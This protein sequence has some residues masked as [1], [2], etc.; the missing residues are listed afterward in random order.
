MAKLITAGCGISQLGF[1]KWPTWPKY[2]VMTHNCE[3]QNVGGPASGNEHIARSIV[4][5][6]YEN[7]PDCVIVTWTSYN[8]LDVFVEDT[9][10]ELQIKNFPTRNFLINYQGKIVNAPAWWPSSVSEDNQW[11]QWYKSTIESK[12][13][14]YIRSLESILSVQ[15]LCEL[16]NIPCYMFLGYDFDFD[17]I[18]G[19]KELNYLYNA[20]NWNLFVKLESLEN[21]YA[22]SEWFLYNTEKK[23]GLVPVAGWHYEFYSN[24]IMPLLSKHFDQRSLEKY[25]LLEGNILS[26]TKEW[27]TKDTL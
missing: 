24:Q 15:Q 1:E 27:F 6:I 7:I 19:N 9:D 22:N 18:Q 21:N 2:C 5:S 20:I 8:K 12:T 3:H 13:Y 23:H 16:K 17:F 26:I 4:R 10:K 11:K 14:Y 25:R